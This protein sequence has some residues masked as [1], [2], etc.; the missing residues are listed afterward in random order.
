MC[1]GQAAR[2]QV[3]LNGFDNFLVRTKVDSCPL[4]GEFK[5]LFL[6][7]DGI[8]ACKECR[9]ILAEILELALEPMSRETVHEQLTWRIRGLREQSLKASGRSVGGVHRLASIER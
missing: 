1:R 9:D 6:L 2:Q 4:C 3:S 7:R 8:T 5:T